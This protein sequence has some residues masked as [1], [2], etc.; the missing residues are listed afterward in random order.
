MRKIISKLLRIILTGTFLASMV[1][2]TS[3]ASDRPAQH[4]GLNPD[5][6]TGNADTSIRDFHLLG[7]T[8]GTTSVI[9]VL[10]TAV[11]INSGSHLLALDMTNPTN[12]RQASVLL[13]DRVPTKLRVFG[14]YAYLLVGGAIHK[15]DLSD[16]LRPI[17]QGVLPYI[18]AY[19]IDLEGST[20]YVAGYYEPTPCFPPCSGSVLALD[21]ASDP[22]NPAVVGNYRVSGYFSGW[23]DRLAAAGKTIYFHH[24]QDY[25]TT[26]CYN[27][28]S[29]DFSDP[30]HPAWQAS[31]GDV[32]IYRVQQAGDYLYVA[33]GNLRVVKA[34]D[35][36]TLTPLAHLSILEEGVT[37]LVLNG[38]W[39]YL[40]GKVGITV[41][42]ISKPAQ[43][44]AVATF[45][46]PGASGVATANGLILF[47]HPRGLEIRTLSDPSQMEYRGAFLTLGILDDIYV[48]NGLALVSQVNDVSIL[49]VTIPGNPKTL[50]NLYL[51][52]GLL[53]QYDHSGYITNKTI[54][55]LDLN[56]PS[57]P[58]VS[59]F[60]LPSPAR[61]QIVQPPRIYLA[62]GVAGLQVVNENGV[63]GPEI[64]G[65]LATS[66]DAL[67]LSVW[68]QTI[69]LATEKDGVRIIDISDP[70]NPHETSVLSLPALYGCGGFSLMPQA[71]WV[72]AWGGVLYIQLV[73]SET[74]GF[75]EV[76]EYGLAIYDLSSPQS[77]VLRSLPAN[78]ASTLSSSPWQVAGDYAYSLSGEAVQAWDVTQPFSPTLASSYNLGSA[79][80]ELSTD[81][82]VIYVAGAEGGYSALLQGQRVYGRLRLAN[83]R[84]MDDTVVQREGLQA[85]TS[86]SQGLYVFHNLAPVDHGLQVKAP[87]G[88]R[89]LPAERLI[90]AAE[91]DIFGQDF[92]LLPAPVM[93][94]F[95]AGASLQVSFS[96]L[97]G[98]VTQFC[99]PSGSLTETTTLT[100]TPTLA[101][102]LPR[103]AFSGHAFELT[104]SPALSATN[105][106]TV[107]M[108]LSD[109]DLRLVTEENSLALLHWDGLTWAS[110]ACTLKVDYTQHTFKARICPAGAYALYGPSRS[111]YFP[112][113]P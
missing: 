38:K 36:A 54:Y 30:A 37:D 22:A 45:I 88:A 84:P 25:K 27:T 13:Y 107:T 2:F 93:G 105:L 8:G 55:F 18:S 77:P 101:P 26:L 14:H 31:V 34:A 11:Y 4:Q 39:A 56:N 71:A 33:D 70:G 58:K 89:A 98:M 51:D 91:A 49:D 21:L 42:D 79:P 78:P 16:P 75:E 67:S 99:L 46:K 81:R 19:D 65:S 53:Y 43:P 9:A 86:D 74:C 32:A 60:D 29:V 113:L 68:D 15:L 106:L 10:G 85:A 112:V 7:N 96:D 100:I 69:Y 44:V 23:A 92:T 17:D 28:E 62:D 64:I 102:H 52:G 72:R 41:V 95:P 109:D 20:L 6:K 35:Q 73:A 5:P 90:P 61:D 59:S 1:L 82:G 97:Q 40:A 94:S 83:G 87:V 3:G 111:T 24:C 50:S 63:F 76:M 12:P 110:D 48:D 47:A 108:Q 80:A 103:M 57:D 66:S 104:A